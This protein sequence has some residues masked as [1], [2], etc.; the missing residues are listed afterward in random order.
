MY[1]YFSFVMKCYFKTEL[2]QLLVSGNTNKNGCVG[3]SSTD[4]SLTFQAWTIFL[5]TTTLEGKK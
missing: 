4:F 1:K 5:E 2:F 3:M